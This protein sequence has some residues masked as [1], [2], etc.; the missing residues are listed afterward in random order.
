M[1]ADFLD[2]GGWRSWA[3]WGGAGLVVLVAHAAGAWI[4]T[5]QQ[6]DASAGEAAPAIMVELAPLPVAPAAEPV[7]VAP[8]PE[9]KD[10]QSEP[11]TETAEAPV[12]SE[13]P[14]EPAEP[15]FEETKPQLQIDAK[16]NIRET[17][18]IPNPAVVLPAPNGQARPPKRPVERPRLVERSKE[19]KQVRPQ[20]RTA[21]APPRVQAAP[22]AAPAAPSASVAATSSMSPANWRGALLAQLNRAKRYPGDARSRRE[23][24]T[25]RLSFSIDRSGRVIGYQI[26]GSSGSASLDQ[27]ALSMI[28]RASPLP[29]PPPEVPGSRIS[30]TVPV[31]FNLN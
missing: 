12:E 5:R 10:V 1:N 15:V 31:R 2:T 20:T 22:V 9:I 30:L 7:D 8:G 23:E 25:V 21:T 3:R 28:Q 18:P 27:E 26:S 13:P 16:L 11:V 19:K 6:P 29:A 4:I 14:P 17:P 24:G